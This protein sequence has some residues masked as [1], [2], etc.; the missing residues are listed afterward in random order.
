MTTDR[1]RS[2]TWLICSV[3]AF[4]VFALSCG[5]FLPSASALDRPGAVDPEGVAAA[6]DDL[7]ADP[8]DVLPVGEPVDAT[9]S[10]DAP[11]PVPLNGLNEVDVPE[12]RI[13]LAEPVEIGPAAENWYEVEGEDLPAFNTEPRADDAP[14]MEMLDVRNDFVKPDE[15]GA[16]DAKG[17]AGDVQKPNKGKPNP[18]VD[19]LKTLT[20]GRSKKKLTDDD[21]SLQDDLPRRSAKPRERRAF[22]VRIEWMRR[23]RIAI[24]ELRWKDAVALLQKVCDYPE[25][26]LYSRPDGKWVSIRDEAQRLI[27][28]APADVLAAYRVEYGGLAKQMLGDA[29]RSGELAD[30]ALVTTQIGRAHV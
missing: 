24:Q 5:Q 7:P 6:G 13:E 26:L 18:I 15:D 29:Q 4:C 28:E 11:A 8:V 16:D 10:D 21:D 27:G 2:R 3:I 12:E 20:P 23:A 30:Y 14:L 22:D 17:G 9:F 1:T 19:L 25:D